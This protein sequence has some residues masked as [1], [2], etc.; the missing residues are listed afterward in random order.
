MLVVLSSVLKCLLIC[1]CVALGV[2]FFT[3][4]ERKV[5]G[6]IQ[7]RKGPNKV[8][9]VGLPQPLS[10]AL[11]LF[12]KEVS[13]VLFSN[14]LIY[15]F[16]PVFALLVMFVLWCLYVSSYGVLFFKLGLLFFLCVSSL[17]VYTVLLSGWSS[18][19]KYALL[20]SVRAVAQTISYEVRMAL[21]LILVLLTCVRFNFFLLSAGQRFF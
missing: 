1:L 9:F 7:I 12:V 18:N 10:D 21:V 15:F 2:G 3:L 13:E 14:K 8:S 4:V 20:G 19:S 16:S 5:L 17:N 6:Y 11:K